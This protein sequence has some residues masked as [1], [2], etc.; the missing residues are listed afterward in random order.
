MGEKGVKVGCRGGNVGGVG[1]EDEVDWGRMQTHWIGLETV[2]GAL[3][4]GLSRRDGIV[5]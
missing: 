3:S 1:E 2:G 5:V 4:I